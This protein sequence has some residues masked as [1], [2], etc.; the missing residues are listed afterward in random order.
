MQ[1]TFR[2]LA[3]NLPNNTQNHKRLIAF[4]DATATAT[5]AE[6]HNQGAAV[7]APLG[8]LGLNK[9]NQRSTSG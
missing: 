6:L 9:K 1:R 3:R 2:E 7:L 5:N 4:S 8:A